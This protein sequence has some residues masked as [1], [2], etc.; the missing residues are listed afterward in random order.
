MH[1]ILNGTPSP[2]ARASHLIVGVGLS[3]LFW[4]ALVAVTR[5]EPVLH[6]GW[7]PHFR[8]VDAS[9]WHDLFRGY[10]PMRGNPRIGEG[11]L[12]LTYLAFPLHSLISPL[13]ILLM[14]ALLFCLLTGTWP[15]LGTPRH[16]ATLAFLSAGVL[17]M[18]PHAGEM[19]F[20]RPYL[21]N[22]VY[23]LTFTLLPFVWATRFK[24]EPSPW[25]RWL[26]WV[27]LGGL[28]GMANEHTGP[29]AIV[30]L[31]VLMWTRW[32]TWKAWPRQ[33][34]CVVV[35][36]V[37]G[38]GFLF[39]SPGQRRRSAGVGQQS[40]LDNMMNRGW[41]GNADLFGR[42][43]ISTLPAWVL[44]AV[45]V[46]V[47]RRTRIPTAESRP[48]YVAL[49]CLV[50][51]WLIV[52]ITLASPIV[53]DRLLFA[54]ATLVVTAAGSVVWFLGQRNGWAW[55]CVGAGIAAHVLFFAQILPVYHRVDEDF[56]ER[57][58]LLEAA[59]QGAMVTV[60]VFRDAHKTHYFYGDDFHSKFSRDTVARAFGL[61]SV[62]AEPRDPWPKAD[63]D[64]P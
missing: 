49:A 45:G 35:G 4:L 55:A 44:L 6:D 60:P 51:A 33:A 16:L 1:K 19:F 57:M 47:Y 62:V 63:E 17:W 18:V 10:S 20:Y 50:A 39:L 26:P 8:A 58:K 36:L 64:A 30:A 25:W 53:G 28:A 11:L 15:N 5:L 21:T 3:V 32:G 40:F 52:A 27:L 54:P 61:E 48:R 56:T 24:G 37:A 38:Y 29:V 41:E 34:W 2:P 31:C 14:F 9:G 42:V 13:M 7:G 22:Y 12:G 23:G 59:P 43:L 46:V